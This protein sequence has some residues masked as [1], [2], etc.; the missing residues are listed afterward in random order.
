[1]SWN[2]DPLPDRFDRAARI[3][4]AW[5]GHG[6]VIVRKPAG[7][8]TV[9]GRGPERADCVEAQVRALFPGASVVT[10][11]HRLDLETSG[12]VAV[13][14]DRAAVTRLSAAF[15]ARTVHKVYEAILEG[16]PPGES[17]R[18]DAAIGPAVRPRFAVRP[19][20]RPAVTRWERIGPRRVRLLPETGRTH[21][22]RLH[23]AWAGGLAAPIA[24]DSLYG[25]PGSAPR[26]LLHA[27]ALA[28]PGLPPVT[29]D[30]PF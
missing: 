10:A 15:E 16:E 17:G 8:L 21:Q 4:L 6:A 22:L 20:G 27:T 12:L 7:L 19:D 13:A 26:L 5:E 24:G 3:A 30:A 11:V 18:I 28:I 25:D 23:A 1:M 14:L 29:W 9:P 2:A